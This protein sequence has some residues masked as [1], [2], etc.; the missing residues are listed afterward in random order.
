MVKI[1]F[2]LTNKRGLE[3]PRVVVYTLYTSVIMIFGIVMINSFMTNICT[4]SE[5][6]TANLDFNNIASRLIYSPDCFAVQESYTDLEGNK[7][8]VTKPGVLDETKLDIGRLNKCVKYGGLWGLEIIELSDPT[9]PHLS[10]GDCSDSEWT[11]TEDF[12]ILLKDSS[13]E[14]SEGKMTFC[15]QA[16]VTESKSGVCN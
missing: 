5:Y 9:H 11:R 3:A 1:K 12:L 6:R 15:L 13:G 2:R 14:L 7:V 16:D 8:Y 10:R 4:V